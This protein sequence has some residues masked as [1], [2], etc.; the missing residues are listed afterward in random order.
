MDWKVRR[1]SRMTLNKKTVLH[2]FL[3]A[4]AI[5]ATTSLSQQSPTPDPLEESEQEE[6]TQKYIGNIF[7]QGL[8]VLPEDTIFSKIPYEKGDL[9]DKRI[10]S[11]AIK[12]IYE[13]GYFKQISFKTASPSAGIID[14]YV[15]LTEK[16]VI[17]DVVFKGNKYLA[18]EDLKKK[19]G[20]QLLAVEPRE[21]KK[22]ALALQ[23]FYAEKNYHF[24]KITPTLEIDSEGKGTVIFTIIE[25]PIALVK[26]VR[27]EGNNH[28][29]GKKLRSLLFTRE[30]WILGILD[31]AG[32]YNPLAVEQDRD[33]LERFYQSNGYLHA[34]VPTADIAFNDKKKEITVTFV[35]Q[36]GDLFTISSVKAPGNDLITEEELLEIIP[37]RAG[38]LYSKELVRFSIDQLR[39]RWGAQGYIYADIDP[40]IEPDDDNKTVAITFFSHPGNTVHVNRINIFG[41]EKGRDKIIRRQLIIEEGDLLTTP[42]MEESKNRVA[43]LGYFD[44][45]EGVNWKINRL[46]EETA[47]LDLLVK[48]IKTGRFEW[49]TSYGGSPTRLDSSNTGVMGELSMS[50]RNLF[51][52]GLFAQVVGRMSSEEKAFNFS[53]AEPWF[54][55]KPVRVGFDAFFNHTSYDEIKKVVG[56]VGEKQLGA[57]LNLGFSAKKLDNTIFLFETG[58][59]NINHLGAAPKAAINSNP[60]DEAEYQLILD[61]RFLGGRFAFFQAAMK[62]NT[63]NHHMHITEGYKW[64]LTS[65][66]AIPSLGDDVIGFYKIEGDAHWYTSIIGD[67]QLVFHS[68]IHGGFLHSL[69]KKVIPYRELFSI[70]GPASVRAWRFGQ[71]SPMWYTNELTLNENWQGESIGGKKAMFLNLELIFPITSNLTMKGCVFYDGGSGWDTPDSRTIRP[72]HLKNNSFD[73]RHCIGLGIRLIEPQPIRVD[74][75]FK[76]DRRKNESLSE[77]QFSGYYDF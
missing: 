27:F 3:L 53:F 20:E 11:E 17:K 32:T 48:E 15:I 42:N 23:R 56:T 33:T 54:C 44:V 57:S 34:K 69:N 61:E 76:L 13:L 4:I 28:F 66:F 14:L 37:L 2:L 47:D 21:L 5:Q 6:A 51:G 10:T 63:L 9:F 39:T 40:S 29:S 52:K 55:D 1:S 41:N 64:D 25:G 18:T 45:K 75:G 31:R 60:L 67:Y 77:V 46:D 7:I 36:E 26:K 68:H 43:Q 38:Q 59:Q 49:K 12:K 62:Q 19:L 72:D 73:Y 24:T 74:W 8:T 58:F 65:K 50:D 22:Y 35:I 70:G 16:T 30:D 71:I